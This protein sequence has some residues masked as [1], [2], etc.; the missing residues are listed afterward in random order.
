M[1]KPKT[2]A[3]AKPRKKIKKVKYKTYSF[4]LSEKQKKIIDKFCKVKKTSPNKLFK[5]A[6]KTYLANY[7]AT[8][9]EDDYITENQLQLFDIEEDCEE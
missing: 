2:K 4:K 3:K 9:P 5:Q 7:I 8:M 6:I 1:V